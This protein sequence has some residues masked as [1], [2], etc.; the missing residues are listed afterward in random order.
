MKRILSMALLAALA[1]PV[2]AQDQIRVSS[3]LE[4]EEKI[5]LKKMTD[6]LAKPGPN[7]PPPMPMMPEAKAPTPVFPTETLAVYGTNATQ[8]EGLLSLGGQTY[9][10]RKGTQVQEYVVTDIGPQGIALSK[11]VP[12]RQKRGKKIITTGQLQ[13]IN[14]PLATH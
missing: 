14:A 2:F 6:E 7:T 11:A 8:Y 5:M 13:T 10:V 4:L 9:T 1:T 3:L 12:V